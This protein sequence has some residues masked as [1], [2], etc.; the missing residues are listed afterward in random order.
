VTHGEMRGFLATSGCA[1]SVR[2]FRH[3]P[4]MLS[5]IMAVPTYSDSA[6]L[7]AAVERALDLV[8]PTFAQLRQMDRRL[9]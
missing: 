4:A 1:G 9:S 5:R 7:L 8:A 3:N 6:S 2:K